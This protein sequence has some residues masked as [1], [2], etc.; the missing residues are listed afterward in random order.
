MDLE[1]VTDPVEKCS[2]EAQIQE[3]G[4]T[5]T[6]LFASAHPSRRD[7]GKKVLLIEERVVEAV[8]EILSV[9][10]KECVGLKKFAF[11]RSLAVPRQAQRLVG[12]LTAQI[13]RRIHQDNVRAWNWSFASKKSMEGFLWAGSSPHNLHSAYAD[14]ISELC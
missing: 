12:G 10:E 1:A 8:E 2:L 3:F 7:T 6:Q 5:P 14:A 11:R 4:Q 13:R 9:D